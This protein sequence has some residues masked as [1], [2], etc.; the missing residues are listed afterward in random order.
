MGLEI[1]KPDDYEIIFI[2]GEQ[3]KED[4]AEV[5][6]SGKAKF[7]ESGSKEAKELIKGHPELEGDLAIV[8]DKDS[9]TG[10]ACAISAVG[11]SLIIHCEDKILPVKE[12]VT[13]EEE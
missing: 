1:K 7:I 5:V 4:T 8:A 10:E 12:P 11:K 6:E 3:L 13:E 9:D 2:G